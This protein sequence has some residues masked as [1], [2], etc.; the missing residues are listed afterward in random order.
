[1]GE[2]LSAFVAL[3]E[4]IGRVELKNEKN[5]EPNSPRKVEFRKEMKGLA[6]NRRRN[7]SSIHLVLTYR[8]LKAL[9]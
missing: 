1:M 2:N 9:K 6:Q 3:I 7:D 5:E 4:T 8:V